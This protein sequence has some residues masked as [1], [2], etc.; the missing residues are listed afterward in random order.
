MRATV[1]ALLGALQCGVASVAVA[2]PDEL[3]IH[4]D[5]TTPKGRGEILERSRFCDSTACRHYFS[6]WPSLFDLAQECLTYV[7]S[8]RGASR[9]P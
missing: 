4:L 9:G 2:V 7:K 1:V 6:A 5:E 8:F 3:E